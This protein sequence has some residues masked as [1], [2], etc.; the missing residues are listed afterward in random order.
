MGKYYFCGTC[1]D[2]TDAMELQKVVHWNEYANGEYEGI[3]PDYDE[4]KIIVQQ[5]FDRMV[6]PSSNKPEPDS[7]KYYAFNDYENVLWAYDK[8]GIH[9]FYNESGIPFFDVEE[10]DESYE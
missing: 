3:D 4:I 2:A 1:I 10:D 9:W 5:Q 7:V 6:A 8:E